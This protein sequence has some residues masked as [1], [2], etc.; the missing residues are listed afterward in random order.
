MLIY[1][2]SGS[3]KSFTSV[4]EQGGAQPGV[5]QQAITYATANIL[6]QNAQHPEPS[7][8]VSEGTQTSPRERGRLLMY[9]YEI[10]NEIIKDL[11]AARGSLS[12]RTGQTPME[13]Q[14]SADKGMYVKNLQYEVCRNPVEAVA[15]FWQAW[16]S[17]T[18]ITTDFGP[19]TNFATYIFQLELFMMTD[20]N[21]L[22]NRSTFTVIRLPGAEKLADD[23]SRTRL[24]EGPMLSKSIMA[25]NK[26]TSDLARQ[27][28]PERVINYSD[29]KL[30]SLLEDIL[31]GNCK[32]RVICCL[33]PNGN[34][35]E[36]LSAV[37]NGCGLLSQ[38]KNYPIINDC[39][40]Q[41]LVTQFRTR[42]N[43][44]L[45]LGGVGEASAGAGLMSRPD[46]QDQLLKITSDNTQLRE[47]N[48]RLFQRL[49]QIQ[50]KMTEI[51]KSK[52][53]ISSK[54][55]ASEEEKLKVSKG[56]VELQLENNRLTEEYES[57]NFELKNK[58]LTLENQ[59][60]EFELEKSKFARSHDLSAEHTRQLEENRKTIADEF[61][62]LKKKALDQEKQLTE[63]IRK[64]N[65]MRA[66][67]G[68]LI[69]TEAALLDLR[70][71]V[72]R[73]RQAHDDAT[74]EL[75]RARDVL[76]DANMQA[77]NASNEDPLEALKARRAQLQ[78]E[79]LNK[80]LLD[81]SPRGGKNDVLSRMRQTYDEQTRKLESRLEE[82]KAQLAAAYAGIQATNKKSAEQT[83]TM[84]ALKERQEKSSEDVTRLQQQLKEA[85]EDYRRRL[86]RYVQDI[87]DFVDN[88]PP[89]GPDNEKNRSKSNPASAT[90]QRYVDGML[91]E[92]KSAFR[93]REE[94]LSNAAR[95]FKKQSKRVSQRHE[96]LLIHYR[97]L[98]DQLEFLGSVADRQPTDPERQ[99]P[100]SGFPP[101][102]LGPDPSEMVVTENDLVSENALEM[103]K[104]RAILA[105]TKAELAGAKAEVQRH[106]QMD[107]TLA[108]LRPIGH[109]FPGARNS[110]DNGQLRMRD[111]QMN[112]Q[113]ERERAELLTRATVAEQQAREQQ[114][115]IDT[116]LTRYKQEIVRLRRILSDKGIPLGGGPDLS[117]RRKFGA[118]TY[119]F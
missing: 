110:Y 97:I 28:E 98:R 40:A 75:D 9:Q 73:R 45:Q 102:D 104:L 109:S 65:E 46:L 57:E 61:V 17:R 53:E 95:N 6:E 3:G 30:T 96:K 41:N 86:W 36:V 10:Y 111:M 13:I 68:R 118:G 26:L 29:S 55:V 54:L 4:G 70:D 48:D 21:P 2:E 63:Q 119:G 18:A 116:H 79:A 19:S 56:L 32:T 60:V 77:T 91:K 20:E 103:N 14:Y 105:R 27:P 107:K 51:A 22:P 52:S 71:N 5:I 8:A 66:E 25:F 62:A 78:R 44:S 58:I 112:S 64:N 39:L 92:M 35:T 113:L 88:G 67:L 31:G 82:L 117:P 47:R 76:R 50:D 114:E 74:K 94:Q 23:L 24:R 12:G 16:V 42:T 34:R 108:P 15:G 115:Y 69:E 7:F 90:M 106:K 38:V 1:G 33:P 43:N 93:S 87:A 100:L 89:S 49:E 85:N 59:L 37:L 101:V 80:S 81:G 83:T 99:S 84:L 72:E 11:M